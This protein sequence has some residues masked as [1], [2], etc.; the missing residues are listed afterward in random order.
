MGARERGRF[1]PRWECEMLSKVE[2]RPAARFC[3]RA[4]QVAVVGCGQWG[5]NIVRNLSELGALAGLVDRNAGSV[6]ALA[7]RHGGSVMSFEQV[8]ADP[9]IDAVAVAVPPAGHYRLAKAALEAGKHVYVEKPLTLS[10]AHAEELCRIAE[11]RD[12]RLMVGHIL[13]YH[14]GFLKLCNLVR[15]GL[16]GQLQYVSASRANLGRIC[17]EED[18]FWDLA[19]HDV[20]MIL[21][22]MEDAPEAVD[23]IGGFYLNRAIA[24]ATTIH[25]AFPGGRQAQVFVSWLYP[26]KEQKLVVVGDR[27]MAVFDDA[28]PWEQKLQLFAHRVEWSGALP[29]AHRADPVSV[30]IDRAEPLRLELQHF[31]DCVASGATPRTDGC[32]ATEVVRI[33]AEAHARLRQRRGDAHAPLAVQAPALAAR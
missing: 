17:S 32:E 4:P 3:G 20:S 16:L 26:F 9:R 1:G 12:C 24:D 7:A 11:Q 33:L 25:L 15:D 5:R 23:C 18:I 31:L 2:P 27:G 28:A 22:L 30:I 21:A 14:P 13:Q 29:V 19:P 6:A 10:V 8:L